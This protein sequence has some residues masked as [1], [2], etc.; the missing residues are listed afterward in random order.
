[1]S[2][3][4]QLCPWIPFNFEVFFPHKLKDKMVNIETFNLNEVL[5]QYYNYDGV[6]GLATR[7]GCDSRPIVG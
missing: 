4:M 6:D 3:K 2:F 7:I 5:M 1:M